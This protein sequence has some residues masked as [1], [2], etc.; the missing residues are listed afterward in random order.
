MNIQA[1]ATSTGSATGAAT[2]VVIPDEHGT[3]EIRAEYAKPYWEIAELLAAGGVRDSVEAG[4]SWTF[5][6]GTILQGSAGARRYRAPGMT[7][8]ATWAATGSISQS[9]VGSGAVSLAYMLDLERA[10]GEQ[11]A[12]LPSRE[13]HAAALQAYKTFAG[14][15]DISGSAG[16]AADR[17]GSGG[18]FWNVSIAWR[19]K[20]GL[21]FDVLID[22]RRYRQW[23]DRDATRV[24][25]SLTWRF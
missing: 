9:L 18:P 3:V 1:T 16:F 4:R 5:T 21:S 7:Q 23:T 12:L 19:P 17:L 20:A 10:R 14:A 2:V 25:G 24:G 11:P 6:A 13:V 22:R 8:A 15:L